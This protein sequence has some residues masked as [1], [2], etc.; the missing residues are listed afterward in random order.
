MQATIIAAKGPVS[1]EVVLEDG[2]RW[3]RRVDHLRR[4]PDDLP[5]VPTKLPAEVWNYDNAE[6]TTPL[7]TPLVVRLLLTAPPHPLGQIQ[8]QLRLLT[9]PPIRRIH[10]TPFPNLAVLTGPEDVPNI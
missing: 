3:K 7:E 4:R 6:Q 10:R 9:L 5:D 2:R 8:S 1:Y